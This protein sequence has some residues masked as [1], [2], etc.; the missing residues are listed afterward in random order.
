LT[1]N[2]QIVRIRF[3]VALRQH[4]AARSRRKSTGAQF[5]FV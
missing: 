5:G 3:V 2:E 4:L 1:P